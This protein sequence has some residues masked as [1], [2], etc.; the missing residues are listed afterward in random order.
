MVLKSQEVEGGKLL[1][2][3]AIV[4]EGHRVTGYVG[5]ADCIMTSFLGR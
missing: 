4:G 3:M 1:N 2:S 5:T